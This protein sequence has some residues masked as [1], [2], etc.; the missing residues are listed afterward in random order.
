M[1]YRRLSRGVFHQITHHL[2]VDQRITRSTSSNVENV[3]P[4]FSLCPQIFL[5]HKRDPRSRSRARETA[6]ENARPRAFPNR[7]SSIRE[8]E[9]ETKERQPRGNCQFSNS[10][11][12][13]I[14]SRDPRTSNRNYRRLR[15]LPAD[16]GFDLSACVR[17]S[18]LSPPSVSVATERYAPR[19][20]RTSFDNRSWEEGGGWCGWG[21]GR[22]GSATGRGGCGRVRQSGSSKAV[23]QGNLEASRRL[24]TVFGVIYV[25][26]YIGS[27]SSARMFEHQ[28]VSRE[29]LRF[30]SSPRSL[31]LLP[32]PLSL[33]TVSRD[34]SPPS[35]TTHE[36]VYAIRAYVLRV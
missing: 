33:V 31:S 17:R 14:S 20:E 27:I 22:E 23:D 35:V 4:S 18:C 2:H 5:P 32:P 26:T 29:A 15:D 19:A 28:Y 21:R 34:P 12:A 6:N 1:H 24:S 3:S 25:V 8:F 16:Y 11:L 10:A 13:G 7:R 9:S 30:R 36:H